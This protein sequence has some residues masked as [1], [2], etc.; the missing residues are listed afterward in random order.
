MG[1]LTGSAAWVVYTLIASLAQTFRNAAQ[2]SLT[3]TLG[4]VGATHVR[5]L[6]GFPFALLF[7]AATVLVSGLAV[8]GP[9]W[10]FLAWTLGGAV[11]QIFATALMLAAMQDRSFA[12]TIAYTKTEPVLVALFGLLVL[13]D[14]V[15]A[16]DGI[17][18][19]VATFGVV[20]M[21]IRPGKDG[22]S[23]LV[24][25]RPL[26]LGVVSAACFALAAV[27][28]RGGILTLGEAPFYMRATTTLAWALGMQSALLTLYLWIVDRPILTAIFR[29]W[30]PSLFAGFAGALA[31]Q[32]WFLGFSLTSAANVRTLALVE[33]FL[34]QIVSGKVF[35]ETP[36]TRELVGMGFIV[37]G[38]GLLMWL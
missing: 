7:L 31:S 35:K 13:G 4:T 20:L 26:I 28:F 5:F 30:R 8:P 15:S 3:D 16:S 24:A 36:S 1:L 14:H 27:G 37:A 23:R 18:I 29:A 17:A 32:F 9:S 19:A 33:V 38:V 21:S 22:A 25:A 2:R 10:P 12:V 11:A 34:A 6:F